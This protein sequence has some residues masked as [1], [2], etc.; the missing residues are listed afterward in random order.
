LRG[1]EDVLRE[2]G[3]ELLVYEA[4]SYCGRSIPE[5]A[6]K[7]RRGK[8]KPSAFALFA[9][10]GY[11]KLKGTGMRRMSKRSAKPPGMRS[12]NVGFEAQKKKGT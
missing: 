5:I 8:K 6:G 1:K 2:K 3:L 11:A 12:V 10:L 4:L 9:H 7:R